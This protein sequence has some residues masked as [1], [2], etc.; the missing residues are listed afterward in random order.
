MVVNI[1]PISL[2]VT[3]EVVKFF[4]A[5]MISW[6][7]E[8]YDTDK[9]MPTKAQSS[10][11]NEELGGIHYIFSDKTGT[12]TQN[13]MEFK[14][15]SVGDF[16]YGE[17]DP[18]VDTERLKR[19]GI[20]NV[21]FSDPHLEEDMKNVAHPNFSNLTRFMEILSVCHTVIAEKA[22]NGSNSLVYN[23]SSPDELALVNA[24]K[25]FGYNFKGRDEDNNML[26]EVNEDNEDISIGS[27]VK[28]YALLNVIE[29]TSTRKRMSVIVRD[30][31]DE[32][33]RVMCKGADSIVIPRLKEF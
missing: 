2:M 25:F 1:V 31:Q 8:M 32:T 33:I 27:P 3:L 19:D 12:L 16:C 23:A 30:L 26:V 9:D 28:Q 20:T 21:N 5:M 6:D 10:N 11:L 13:V 14:K 22:K 18:Q 29:F 15:F 24:A 4:Q 17:S 7:V